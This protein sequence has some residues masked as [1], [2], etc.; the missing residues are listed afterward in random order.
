MS[1]TESAVNGISAYQEQ[2]EEAQDL[3]NKNKKEVNA[4]RIKLSNLHAMAK[5]K[6]AKIKELE[7]SVGRAKRILSV[8][9]QGRARSEQHLKASNE[10]VTSLKDE[11]EKM[12]GQMNDLKKGKIDAQNEKLKISRKARISAIKLKET[13]KA[14]EELEKSKTVE[15]LEKRVNVLNKTVSSL[16]SQNSKLRGE[17]AAHKLKKKTNEDTATQQMMPRSS[18]SRERPMSSRAK[19]LEDQVKTL[20][21]SLSQEKKHASDSSSML[22]RYQRRIYSL[23]NAIQSATGTNAS[24][25][26][27]SPTT[28]GNSEPLQQQL[29]SLKNENN[30]LKQRIG[31][32]KSDGNVKA[33]IGQLKSEN[34]RLKKENER[35]SQI[36]MRRITL[37][38]FVPRCYLHFSLD[39]VSMADHL[40]FFEEIGELA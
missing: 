20:Q 34:D 28:E 38:L 1:E 39:Y 12:R 26:F 15:E 19:I 27:Q 14:I 25:E 8:T 18:I 24:E 23:E 40:D 13:S 37:V 11:L 3:L 10:E 29:L 21:R 7:D 36:G 32:M 5:E 6:D 16:A 22:D 17:L 9:R 2:H 31:D 30:S 33:Q 4:M 35:L